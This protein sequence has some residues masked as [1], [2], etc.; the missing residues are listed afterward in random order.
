ME[1]ETSNHIVTTLQLQIIL[2]GIIFPL[3]ISAKNFES[4]PNEPRSTSS[5]AVKL[6][7]SCDVF[8]PRSDSFPMNLAK[9]TFIP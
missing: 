8:V 4:V 1:V 2:Y 5:L 3:L 9:K 7:G 6:R